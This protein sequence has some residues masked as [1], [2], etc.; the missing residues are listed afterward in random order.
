MC[1][2]VHAICMRT[3]DTGPFDCSLPAHTQK[4]VNLSSEQ[5]V[6]KVEDHT[7]G[8]RHESICTSH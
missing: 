1:V 3:L 7:S 6:W 8:C 4:C 5:M 2:I